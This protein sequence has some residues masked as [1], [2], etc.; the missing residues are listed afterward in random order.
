M[1]IANTPFINKQQ[2]Y[3]NSLII[4]INH[5]GSRLILHLL[6][7]SF[8]ERFGGDVRPGGVL[9]LRR[10]P[11]RWSLQPSPVAVSAGF[12]LFVRK[13]SG[14]NAR[15]LLLPRRRDGTTEDD[16]GSRV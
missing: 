9:S 11:I 6:S 4:T 8:T 15:N 5:L 12:G 13:V 2:I 3:P 1:I 16:E 10:L 14:D 7:H